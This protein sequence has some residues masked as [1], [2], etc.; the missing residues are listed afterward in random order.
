MSGINS[1]LILA[2]V[3]L[4]LYLFVPDSPQNRFGVGYYRTLWGGQ[5][6]R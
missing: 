6:R 2:I 1:C 5:G 4:Y 3:V